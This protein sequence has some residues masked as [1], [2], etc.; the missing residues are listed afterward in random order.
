VH[1][2][3]HPLL[4]RAG[5]TTRP[6]WLGLAAQLQGKIGEAPHSHDGGADRIPSGSPVVRDRGGALE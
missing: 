2:G 5:S 4:L 6:A 3:R 1:M